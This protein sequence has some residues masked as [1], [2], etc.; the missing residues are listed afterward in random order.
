VG[1]RSALDP[2]LLRQ[3]PN[4]PSA[5][6][7]RHGDLPRGRHAA[8]AAARGDVHAALH[9]AGGW[10]RLVAGG[11]E[12]ERET[13]FPQGGGLVFVPRPLLLPDRDAASTPG[14][15]RPTCLDQ[16]GRIVRARSRLSLIERAHNDGEST[17]LAPPPAFHAADLTDDDADDDAPSASRSRCP[18]KHIRPTQHKNTH[19]DAARAHPCRAG[20]PRLRRVHRL[21]PPPQGHP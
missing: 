19:A 20:P 15:G 8:A 14:Q 13:V 1:A 5:T 2:V 12:Q 6:S 3:K 9:G 4:T 11:G 17:P 16:T 18:L 7:G 21:H 10:V